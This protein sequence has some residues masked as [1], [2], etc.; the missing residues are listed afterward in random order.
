L[1][2]RI[3]E[4]NTAFAEEKG[5]DR[6]NGVFINEVTENSAAE[7]AGLKAGDVITAVDGVPT[8]RNSELLEQLGRRRPGDNVV[9]TYERG[10]DERQA[11]ARLKNAEGNTEAILPKPVPEVV[12]EL[13]AE[14]VDV[15]ET[16]AEELEISG[17]VQ[18]ADIKSG[19]LYEQTKLRPGFIITHVDDRRVKDVEDF[20]KIMS[21][22]N[23]AVGIEG[24]YPDNPGKV[25]GLAIKK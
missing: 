18:I 6:D 14:F 9:I 24:V 20:N 16:V 5:I 2:A 25:I 13:G 15:D 7:E 1:G 3:I 4:L 11:T 23:G 8:L 10:G 17:G 12:S 19:L 21:R 22:A